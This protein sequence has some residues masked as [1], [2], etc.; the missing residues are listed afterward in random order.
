MHRPS[1]VEE[2]D[3]TWVDPE[4]SLSTG[5]PPVELFVRTDGKAPSDDEVDTVVDLLRGID[6]LVLDA[7]ALILENYSYEYFR[8]L[9]KSE[10]RLVREETPEAMAAAITLT[11]IYFRSTKRRI[12]ELSFAAPWDDNHSFDVEFEDGVA[13]GCSV[14]G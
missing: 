14:N 3:A 7:A 4:F 8:R 11:S 9:G 1:F 10:D 12:F 13:I 2:E 5:R 6:E